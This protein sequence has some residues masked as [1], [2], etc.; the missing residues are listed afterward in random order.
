M[1]IRVPAVAGTFYPGAAVALRKEIARFRQEGP[2]AAPVL[3]KGILVPHAGYVYS[4]PIAGQ[5]YRR[6]LPPDL[7]ILLG[8]NHTG[9]GRPG[10]LWAQGSWKTPLGE[11]P[12]D[13]EA[14][15]GLLGASRI[16]E[17][18][19][20]AHAR[21]HSLEV[22]IPFLQALNP[23]IRIVPVTLG[24][25]SLERSLALGAELA[26]FVQGYPGN[27]LLLA[28]SDMN[29]YLPDKLT[30]R[31][32]RLALEPLLALDAG[33]LYQAVEKND[34]SMCGYIPATA[35]T[36]AVRR[37]GAR[38]AELVA[39]GTSGDTSGDFE[40]VVGYAGVIFH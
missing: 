17:A 8:P 27:T 39:Y 24:H 15:A 6:I 31:L 32:D 12:I 11:V 33:A 36:A 35:V 20:R 9:L 16:L 7:C 4:G 10:A 38:H 3:A 18:D 2:E 25:L 23:K 19:E 22:Q 29:H 28:S 37:M 34:L 14:A 40:R 30:R 26:A 1:S 13:E 21:E 5:V